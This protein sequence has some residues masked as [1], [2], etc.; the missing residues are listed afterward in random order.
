M[1]NFLS[2]LVVI[3]IVMMAAAWFLYQRTRALISE[4]RRMKDEIGQ[5]KNMGDLLS[6]TE[7]TLE[8]AGKAINTAK[9]VMD[10]R[11]HRME[12][13]L[14]EIDG[15]MPDFER[16]ARTSRE[17]DNFTGTKPATGKAGVPQR[18]IDADPDVDD[19]EFIAKRN[20]RI[21][22]MLEEGKTIE[23]IARVTGASVREIQLIKK[24]VK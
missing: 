5:L 1:S 20:R 18:Q 23:E 17:L 3:T 2:F 9:R 19:R 15:K 11:I 8:E 13:L 7:G 22:L 24:F 21:I 16:I 4:V 10:G 12:E 6:V 14:A